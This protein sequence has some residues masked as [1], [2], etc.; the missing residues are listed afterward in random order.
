MKPLT[1]LLSAKP[2]LTAQP[3]RFLNVPISDELSGL[4]CSI[5]AKLE[6]QIFWSHNNE[7]LPLGVNS[8]FN[9]SKDGDYFVSISSLEWTG[10]ALD[11]IDAEGTYR[12]MAENV[13]GEITSEEIYLNPIGK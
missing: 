9:I 7:S 3:S 13:A 6:A 8:T 4:T 5:R 1:C 12:C 11:A 10:S 2:R